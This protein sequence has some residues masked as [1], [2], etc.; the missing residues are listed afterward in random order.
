M[1][2]TSTSTTTAA[3]RFRTLTVT[4]VDRLCPDAVA[5]EF[6]AV[7]G[8]DFT[9]GQSLTLR[10][11]VDGVECRRSYS[12]CAAEG[13]RLRIGVREVPGG[14]VSGWL[15]HDLRV[16][17]AVEVAPPSGR[18]RLV[19]PGMRHLCIAAGSGIT[20][21]LAITA[22]VLEAGGAVTLLYGNRGVDSVMFAEEL[23]D[24]KDLHPSRLQ[25]VHVL[26]R[27][28]RDPALFSGRLDADRL[29]RL[30]TDVVPQ[31]FDHVWLCGPWPMV[32]A[33]REVLTDHGVPPDRIH[34]ELF[35]VDEPPAPPVRVSDLPRGD[36]AEVEVVLEGRR[37]VSAV[38]AGATLLEGAQAGR[39]DLPFA[40]RGGVCGTCRARVIEGSVQMRRNYALDDAELAAGFVLTCQAVPT[41]DRVVVDFDT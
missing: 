11:I 29:R 19:E 13:Q 21:V 32:T 24:L 4:R 3:T 34:T 41:S 36:G 8:F 14:A 27:E 31:R 7:D 16:G 5:V 17:D 25:L 39:A 30:L 26:S 20:P 23:A 38:A 1:V 22:T 18:F 6:E 35:F 28:P 10:R 15:V 2:T 40:C 37:T 33:S 9:A 12:I